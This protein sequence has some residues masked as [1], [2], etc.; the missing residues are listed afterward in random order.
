MQVGRSLAHH[1]AVAGG[2]DGCA[3]GGRRASGATVKSARVLVLVVGCYMASYTPCLFIMVLRGLG[4]GGGSERQL[5]MAFRVTYSLAN[6]NFVVNP[7]TYAWK[8]A[9]LKADIVSL[10]TRCSARR[11][12]RGQIES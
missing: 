10:W 6:L 7:F 5:E 9:P 1:R 8:N 4:V 12:P 3:A 2:G 11:P